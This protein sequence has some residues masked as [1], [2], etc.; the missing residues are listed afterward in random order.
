[1]TSGQPRR[2]RSVV[3]TSTRRQ[4]LQD[5]IQAWEEQDNCGDK[6]TI[7]ALSDRT[8]LEAGTVAKVLDG[9]EGVDRRT[10]ERFFNAFNLELIQNN[11]GKPTSVGEKRP[12]R[13]T[14]VEWGE[15]VDV[16]IF[17]RCI[18]ELE[19]L[20]QWVVSDHCR[21]I[22]LLEMGDIGKTS[23]AA[24]LGEQ[25]QGKFDLRFLSAERLPSVH[26]ANGRSPFQR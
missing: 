7:E 15:A 5:A 3:P 18:A 6:L 20:K 26:Y 24:K 4:K 10:L 2:R 22:A 13:E 21:L 1:M 16:S 23:L 9:E 12:A 11:Y 25:I 17:Y 14:R 8:K 19:T